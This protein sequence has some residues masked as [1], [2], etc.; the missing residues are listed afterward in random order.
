MG[1]Q[2]EIA[3]AILHEGAD[4]CLAVKDNQPTLAQGI[5][6]VVVEHTTDDFARLDARRHVTEEEGHGRKERREYVIFRAP[7]DLPDRSRWPRLAAVGLVFTVALRDGKETMDCRYYILSTYL[8]AKRFAEA[9]RAHWSIENRLHWQ[10]DVT[11]REDECRICKDHAHA[12]FSHLRRTALSLLKNNHTAK[13][14]V[15][16]KRLL[17]ALDPAYLLE[18]LLGT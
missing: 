10:L 12:N 15:K 13:V 18:V 3:K 17:A 4:Y 11:F 1:C 5:E 14:G 8:S 6:A 2:V 7:E 16:N 9:V